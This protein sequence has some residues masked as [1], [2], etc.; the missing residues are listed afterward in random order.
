MV[1]GC[2][3]WQYGSLK[4]DWV[5][6]FI[7]IV[8]GNKHQYIDIYHNLLATLFIFSGSKETFNIQRN[9]EM[10]FFLF[11][12]LSRDKSAAIYEKVKIS[13]SGKIHSRV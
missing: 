6:D 9:Y 10:H 5:N 8:F 7:V 2:N 11:G 1:V 3:A 4:A 13:N 12:L